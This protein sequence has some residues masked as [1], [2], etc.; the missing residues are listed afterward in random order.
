MYGTPPAKAAT[1][2]TE[3]AVRQLDS[4]DYPDYQGMLNL[5]KS[6]SKRLL[7]L[8]KKTKIPLLKLRVYQKGTSW[9]YKFQQFFENVFCLLFFLVFFNIMINFIDILKILL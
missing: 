9:Q 6:N 2:C 1:N 5:K 3:V 7:N 8:N 4:D